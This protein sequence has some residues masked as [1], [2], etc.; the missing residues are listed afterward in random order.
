MYINELNTDYGRIESSL[1]KNDCTYENAL[2]TDYGR[3]ER[4]FRFYIQRAEVA[5]RAEQGREAE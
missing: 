3:I 1:C 5:W 4:S 2:N